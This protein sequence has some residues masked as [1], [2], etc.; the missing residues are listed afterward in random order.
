MSDMLRFQEVCRAG[1]IL[2]GEA[3]IDKMGIEPADIDT[4]VAFAFASLCLL[5]RI[6]GGTATW[7]GLLRRAGVRC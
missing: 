4:F 5:E 3:T 1:A 2:T 6:G 7:F